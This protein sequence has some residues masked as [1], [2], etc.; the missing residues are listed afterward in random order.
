M[1]KLSKISLAAAVVAGGG[2]SWTTTAL[3]QETQRIEITGSSIKRID[4]E[5]SL[6]VTTISR[7]DIERSGVTNVEQ[8]VK[9]ISSV[10]TA[11]STSGSTLSGLA[12]YGLSS[13]SLRGLGEARTL[14]LVN[15]RRLATFAGSNGS[16]VAVDI[17]A[18]PLAA[19]ERVEVLRDGASSLY[20]SDA[21]AGVI[22][23]ILRSDYTGLELSAQYGAPTRSG[24][25]AVSRAGIVFGTGSVDKDRFNVMLAA[26]VEKSES[27]YGR[28]RN[29]AKSGVRPPFFFS[30]ATPSG[31]KA[32]GPRT[33][34]GRPLCRT[35]ARAT[36]SPTRSASR[37]PATAI[38]RRATPSPA[39]ARWDRTVARTSRCFSRRSRAASAAPSTTA[40]TI[41]RRMWAFSRRTTTRTWWAHSS[42]RSIR[43]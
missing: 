17:N 41:R 30:G 33:P 32:S 39:P 35:R 14:V 10:A 40:F 16:T 3:A 37:L 7:A 9:A 19:I 21:V 43:T 23:F 5:S 12:T 4:A 27:L 15:G 20:G 1:L 42:S 31:S 34:R 11:G 26:N 29:F 6:P 38:R 22:N 28:E 24:G 8:L 25:G 18:V 2:L 13:V 36:R